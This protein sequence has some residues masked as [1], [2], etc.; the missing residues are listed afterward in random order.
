MNKRKWLKNDYRSE[1]EI[2]ATI[3]RPC[4]IYK[5]KPDTVFESLPM[6]H[7]FSWLKLCNLWI[8][9]N[10][11]EIIYVLGRNSWCNPFLMT[12][13]IKVLNIADT[14]DISANI[15]VLV[16]YRYDMIKKFGRIALSWYLPIYML[17]NI[18]P[19]LANIAHCRFL[20]F[21]IYCLYGVMQLS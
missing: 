3:T 20:V 15:S 8:G 7:I 17:I 9:C 14:T 16:P 18:S 12:H 5:V 10:K 13:V 2:V 1:K 19:I 6:L 4:I 21:T 11:L